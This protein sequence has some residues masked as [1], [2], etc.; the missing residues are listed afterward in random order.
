MPL[1]HLALLARRLRSLLRRR[2]P[3]AREHPS[4]AELAAYEADE[5][6]REKEQEIQEHF[7]DCR[8]CPEMLLDMKSFVSPGD[9]GGPGLP[10]SR[11]D[12]AW[13]ALRSRLEDEA[14]VRSFEVPAGVERFLLVFGPRSGELRLRYRLEI[15]ASHG[16]PVWAVDELGRNDAGDLVLGLAGHLLPE[17]EYLVRLLGINGGGAKLLEEHPIRLS[18]R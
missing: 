15:L 14:R 4:M 7:L 13:E 3:P 17:G 1:S 5:L 10:D 2:R 9:G 8:E 12:S 18:Y 16:G 6:P 11:V